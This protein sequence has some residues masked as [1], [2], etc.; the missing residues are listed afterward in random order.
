M[1]LL[2]IVLTKLMCYLHFVDEEVC[3]GNDEKRDGEHNNGQSWFTSGKMIDLYTR[4]ME[5]FSVGH[6]YFSNI[7]VVGRN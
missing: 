6:P 7:H 4:G 2:V 3:N 5:S 1:N